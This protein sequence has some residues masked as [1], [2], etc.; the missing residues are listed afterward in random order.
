MMSPEE[1]RSYIRLGRFVLFLFILIF[2]SSLIFKG[3]FAGWFS[4]ATFNFVFRS[5][6]L[7]NIIR[8]N[9]EGS[10]GDWAVYIEELSKGEKY[11]LKETEEFPSA[12]LYKLYL[13]AA[14]LKE[15]D[16][17]G[18]NAEDLRGRLTLDSTVTAT[19]AHLVNVY[20]SLD[21]G[22]EEAPENIV[23]TIE[24]ALTRI[25]RVSD[26]FASI[27]LT[28]KIGLDKIQ[29][30]VDSLGAVGTKIKSPTLI[31]E[32]GDD[33]Y[34]STT[35]SDLGT[36]FKKLYRKEIISP[37][38]SDK[39]IEFLSLNQLNDRIPAGIPKGVR[40]IHKTGELV[41]LRHD[42]GIVCLGPTSEGRKSS[43]LPSYTS[44]VCTRAYVIV[45]LSQ[46]LQDESKGIETMKNISKEVYE[47][48]Q[49]GR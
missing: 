5:S 6:N 13:M 46:N 47:Y 23:Y 14:V 38:A 18:Q 29:E 33:P 9:L 44:E 17:A 10:N 32:E 28:D 26:N 27:M 7:S 3:P 12:S 2:L 24:E 1:P 34:I 21:S 37:A 16:L 41:R 36:F 43:G 42:T 48:F 4:W 40:V 8:N 39:L 30:M 19:K 49:E 11:G 31:L 25:G 20:G 45:L 22:Y 15:T 35:A